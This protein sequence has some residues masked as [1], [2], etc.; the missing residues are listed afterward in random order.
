MNQLEHL[1]DLTKTLHEAVSKSVNGDQREGLI[2]TITELIDKREV[3]IQNVK[4]PFTNEES[5]M[6]KKLVE[7]DKEIEAKLQSIFY[8]VKS[9]ISTLKEKKK[10][11]TKYTNPYKQLSNHDGM[12]MDHR[13]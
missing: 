4:P 11:N 9:D 6:G 1:L 8:Q 2:G 5:K 12:F 10:S 3:I 13:K 7:I